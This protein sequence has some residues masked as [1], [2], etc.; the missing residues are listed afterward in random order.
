MASIS[1]YSKF[2]SGLAENKENRIFLNSDEEHGLIVYVNL[3]KIAK[4]QIR[5]FAGRL[6]EHIGNKPE[7]VEAISEFIERGGTVSILLNKYDENIIVKSPL[8]MRLAYYVSEKK[9]ISVKATE[10][11]AHLGN[12]GQVHFAIA[13]DTAYRLET[14]VVERTAQ[15]NFNNATIAAK[16]IEVFDKVFDS[17]EY[18]H[19]INLMHLFAYDIK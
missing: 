5:I 13:D 4:K 10:V 2:V 16:L 15:C 1:D 19:E 17:K 3:L 9:N 12:N 11:T 7:F 18:S 8:F 6:C 14:D